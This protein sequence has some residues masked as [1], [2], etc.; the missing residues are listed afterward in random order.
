MKE[1]RKLP[2]DIS[3]EIAAMLNALPLP[4]YILD[5]EGHILLANEQVRETFDWKPS[6]LSG[7][8]VSEM[9]LFA[10][11]FRS[12]LMDRLREHGSVQEESERLMS[13]GTVRPV[14]THWSVL[15]RGAQPAL[16]LGTDEDLAEIRLHEQE[17]EQAR[18][19]AKIG[20]LSEGIAH[21]LRNPLSYALSAVQLLSDERISEEVRTQCIQTISTG[22]RKAG[23]IVE[24]LLSLGKPRKQFERAPVSLHD[25]VT[26]AQ[27]AAAAHPAYRKVRIIESV[28]EQ[29]FTVEGNHD[30]LVQV[31]HN[32]I[33]NALN[34]L[35]EGGRIDITGEHLDEGMCIR[36]AD[37]G[38]GVSE[39]QMRHL[40]DPFY[41]ASSSGTGTGLGLTLS[42]Y[43]MKEHGGTIEV[44]SRPGGGAVFIL[45]FP[46]ADAG[47]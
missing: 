11:P 46:P 40:F 45:Q 38:P 32:V 39:E 1:R 41:S 36:I 7:K 34:E 14:R 31:F 25:A 24:N 37:T 44:E 15:H 27:D 4:G 33:T 47:P 43:I 23:L 35:P 9:L 26:E 20:V 30:M 22:L 2:Q 12:T 5:A 17:L 21:E 10:F 13:D 28:P 19:L 18:K 8:Q 16:Y 29:N 6:E 42:Y 3:P